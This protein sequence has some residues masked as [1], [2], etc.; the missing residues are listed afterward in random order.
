MK[1]KHTTN[2]LP[3][4]VGLL[5]GVL[6]TSLFFQLTLS[7]SSGFITYLLITLCWLIGS[8]IGVR[9]IAQVSFPI[10]WMLGLMILSYFM[11]ELLVKSQ[12]FN[13]N[14][15]PL[16]GCLT[17]LV[18]FYPGVFFAR[19]SKVYTARYLFLWENNGFII[20]IILSTLFFM[21]LGQIMLS[22]IAVIVGSYIWKLSSRM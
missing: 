19:L 11:I 18:G 14:L 3:L 10:Q 15:I 5:L 9:Y 7:M 20:G 4:F 22:I 13:T 8:A 1:T 21:I 6:Q 2:L 12:P 16:Y 17:V